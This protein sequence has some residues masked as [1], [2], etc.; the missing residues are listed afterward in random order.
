MAYPTQFIAKADLVDG[1]HYRGR[2]RNTDIARWCQLTEAFG[3]FLYV[4]RKFGESFIDEI[5]H[6]EDDRGFDVFYPFEAV[7]TVEET[8]RVSDK[9]MD[10]ARE[11]RSKHDS[12][13]ED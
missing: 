7:A 3:V 11:S 8:Q 12:S 6:P 5:L 4:R 10:R 9:A 13:A 1:Q 2:C